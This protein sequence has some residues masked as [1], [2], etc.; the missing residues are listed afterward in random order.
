MHA[1]G[2]TNEVQNGC[3]NVVNGGVVALTGVDEVARQFGGVLPVLE[4]DTRPD[5]GV[6]GKDAR[7][8][9]EAVRKVA[10]KLLFKI[11]CESIREAQRAL[12]TLQTQLQ[13]LQQTRRQVLYSIVSEGALRPRRDL[14]IQLIIRVLSIPILLVLSH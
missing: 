12:L 13:I 7:I 4:G 10:R 14:L 2:F 5:G 6:P 8:I 9:V 11:L 3:G 1:A